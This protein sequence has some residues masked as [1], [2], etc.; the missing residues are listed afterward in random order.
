MNE[1]DYVDSI[2]DAKRGSHERKELVDAFI[3]AYPNSGQA[4]LECALLKCNDKDFNGAKELIERSLIYDDCFW[5]RLYYAVIL[6][7]LKQD[8]FAEREF[9]CALVKAR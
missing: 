2:L 9:N 4:L 6:N 1:D 7:D 3:K 5:G 8:E